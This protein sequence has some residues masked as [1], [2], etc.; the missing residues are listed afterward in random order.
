MKVEKTSS[1]ILVELLRA[2]HT[3]PEWAFFA[4]L[5]TGTGYG[6]DAIQH[7]D[8]FALDLYPSKEYRS[9]AYEV[10]VSRGDFMREIDD[11]GKRAFA[12]KVAGECY[13]A[14]PAGLVKVDE[15]PEGWGLLECTTGGLRVAKIATQRKPEPWS[16]SFLASIARRSADPKPTMKP[17]AWKYAGRDLTEDDLRQVAKDLFDAD[18]ERQARSTVRLDERDTKE[19]ADLRRLKREVERALGFSASLGGESLQRAV[20]ARTVGVDPEDVYALRT[21]AKALGGL[22]ARVDEIAQQG[23]GVD[24][25]ESAA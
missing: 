8:A 15:I 7:L 14:A 4:E 2:R 23:A 25:E 6:R 5:R 22:L 12:E 18:V 10:K 20:A 1:T 13:F 21:A 3:P 11:P 17:Q 9:V 19:L 16:M 24:G